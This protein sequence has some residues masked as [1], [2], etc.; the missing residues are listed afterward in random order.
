MKKSKI[1]GF[2]VANTVLFSLL[3]ASAFAGT[4]EPATLQEKVQL[5]INKRLAAEA[6]KYASIVNLAPAKESELTAKRAEASKAYK[7]WHDLKVSVATR[8]PSAQ[9]YKAVELASSEYSRANKAFIELQKSILA[10]NG[11]PFHKIATKMVV[12]E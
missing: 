8:Y 1:A 2:A 3:S 12:M 9:D 4:S 5:S 7:K 11:V 10:Q 6:D